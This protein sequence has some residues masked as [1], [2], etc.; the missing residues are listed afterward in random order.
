MVADVTDETAL[1]VSS[2]EPFLHL[3]A[4]PATRATAHPSTRTYDP[5]VRQAS[6]LPAPEITASSAL[7]RRCSPMHS[8]VIRGCT[9]I[10]GNLFESMLNKLAGRAEAA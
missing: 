4:M 3:P 2:L 8:Q 7:Y 10:F 9:V 1:M 6:T 5:P